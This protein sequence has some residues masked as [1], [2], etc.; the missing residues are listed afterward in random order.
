MLSDFNLSIPWNTIP[1]NLHI[2]PA[3]FYCNLIE[4]NPPRPLDLLERLV[5]SDQLLFNFPDKSNLVSLLSEGVT[6]PLVVFCDVECFQD[7]CSL[8]QLG[9]Y[10]YYSRVEFI[11]ETCVDQ[12]FVAGEGVVYH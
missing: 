7:G 8:I 12:A 1:F 9:H 5:R 4:L 2:L 11:G 3:F 6:E 10:Y